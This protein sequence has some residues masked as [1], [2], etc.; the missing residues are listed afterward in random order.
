MLEISTPIG[1]TSYKKEIL[2]V[3]FFLDFKQNYFILF[4]N[5]FKIQPH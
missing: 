3:Y 4:I 2:L 5:Q 1:I